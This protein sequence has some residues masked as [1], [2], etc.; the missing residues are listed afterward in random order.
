MV[1]D[2]SM[3]KQLQHKDP[4]VAEELDLSLPPL[5]SWRKQAEWWR[6]RA[7]HLFLQNSTL[8]AE[9]EK[10]ALL[11]S[12]LHGQVEALT[13]KLKD[14]AHRVFGRKTE[15]E[16]STD[17]DHPDNETTAPEN[18]RCRG[19][20]RGAPGHGRRRHPGFLCAKWC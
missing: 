18:S 1:Y 13:A 17:K 9:N 15:K 8:K 4:M 14:L 7:I 2:C 3:S 10:Q 20:R 19:Q 16:P 6:A 11:V 5:G 12:D